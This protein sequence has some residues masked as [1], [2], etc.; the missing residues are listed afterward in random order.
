MILILADD[1]SG[2]AELAGI[3]AGRGFTAEVQTAVDMRSRAEVIALDTQTRSRS[4]AEAARRVAAVFREAQRLRPEWVYKKTDSALRGNIAAELERLV[5]E[6]AQSRILFVPANPGKGRCIVGGR[7]QINGTPLDQTIFARDP[8]HPQRSAEVLEALGKPGALARHSLRRNQPSPAAGF[9]V[10]DVALAVDV[11]Y[12]A[13]EVDASTLPAGAA[14]F[15]AALLGRR[16][17]NDK[18]SRREPAPLASAGCLFVCGSLASWE[19][20]IEALAVS[21]GVPVFLPTAQADWC[22]EAVRSLRE[23]GGAMM[24]VGRPEAPAMER[25]GCHTPEELLLF[26]AETAALVVRAGEPSRI[27]VEGGATAS[28][29]RERLGWSRFEALP[30]RLAGV[31]CLCPLAVSGATW[32]F[33]KPGSYPW[34]AAVWPGFSALL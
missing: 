13:A 16:G 30:V 3:A 5:Q 18:F 23:K 4:P 6:T 7:L 33:V 2:A 14:E 28:A 24:A 32:L 9:I 31:G 22:R 11:E 1:L 12:R 34:P 19:Q 27:F 26:L 17:G 25:L 20:G 21:R 8:E 10:P 29:L 15:F